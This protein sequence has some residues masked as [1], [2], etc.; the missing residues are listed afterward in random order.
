MQ[1]QQDSTSNVRGITRVLDIRSKRLNSRC[2]NSLQSEYERRR[3]EKR[4][5]VKIYIWAGTWEKGC[6]VLFF[7]IYFSKFLI[8]LLFL[9]PAKQNKKTPFLHRVM[10]AQRDGVSRST[11]TDRPTELPNTITSSNFVQFSSTEN[12]NKAY[13]CGFPETWKVIA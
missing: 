11:C 8:V 1:F 7:K 10:A 4:S 6:N 3:T 2:L 9:N 5:E 13:E 12:W